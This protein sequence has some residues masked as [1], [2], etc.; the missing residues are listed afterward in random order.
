MSGGSDTR[1]SAD[2]TVTVVGKQEQAGFKVPKQNKV[3]KPEDPFKIDTQMLQLSGPTS[4]TG[5]TA[6]PVQLTALMLIS[7]TLTWSQTAAEPCLYVVFKPLRKH[8]RR[9]GELRA[10]VIPIPTTR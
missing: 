8:H 9:T 1:R 6:A 3:V 10:G 2:F 5:A 4:I 7:D